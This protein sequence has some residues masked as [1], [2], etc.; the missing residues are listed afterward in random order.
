HLKQLGLAM[1]NYE[2]SYRRLPVGLVTQP[3]M[4]AT[5]G[6]SAGPP[7]HTA[8]TQILPFHEQA[9]IEALY[10]YDHRNL[11][12]VNFAATSAQMPIYQCPSDDSTGRRARHDPNNLE[13]SRSNYVACA[14]NDT[15]V[16]NASGVTLNNTSSFS[17][18][19]L[20][21]NGAFR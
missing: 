21:N 3:F 15:M 18:Q 12:A 13:F 20:D 17:T 16:A 10:S 1:A 5:S 2:S 4:A 9:T 6:A 14:G 7:G 8:L 11:D 19:Q